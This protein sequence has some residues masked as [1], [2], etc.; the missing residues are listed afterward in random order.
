[1]A[2]A[3]SVSLVLIIGEIVPQAICTGPSQIKIAAFLAP[4]TKV[5]YYLFV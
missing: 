3:I 2:I 5:K 4:L 1:M